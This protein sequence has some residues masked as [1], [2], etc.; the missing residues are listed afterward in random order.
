MIKTTL[1]VSV[2][3]SHSLAYCLEFD[4]I[5]EGIFL[6]QQKYAK[7]LLKMLGKLECKSIS[8]PIEVNTKLCVLCTHEDKD[9]QDGMM[10]GSLI[11]L[12]LT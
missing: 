7:D 10:I 12:M 1:R 8:T 4:Q 11:Y 9:L 6:C 3:L 2:A 5:K